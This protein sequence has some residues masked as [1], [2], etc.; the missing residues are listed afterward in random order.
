VFSRAGA[1]AEALSLSAAFALFVLL[2][3]A[4]LAATLRFVE[5]RAA[6]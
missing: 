2:R 1:V 3:V 5:P 6:A 4:A